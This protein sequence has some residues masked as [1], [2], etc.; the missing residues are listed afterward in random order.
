MFEPITFK[1]GHVP[2]THRMD[3]SEDREE[4]APPWKTTHR[5]PTGPRPKPRPGP[6]CVSM[7]SDDSMYEPIWLKPGRVPQTQP[8]PGPGPGPESGSG[9]GPSCVSM[10]SDASMFE[11]IEFKPSRVPQTQPGP[12][13]GPSSVSMKS[14]DSKDWLIDFKQDGSSESAIH[15]R[16]QSSG[17]DPGPSCVSFRSDRSITVPSDFS[18]ETVEQQSSE[19]PTGL[20][21]QTQLDSIFQLLEE[22]ICTFV[23]NQL[24][25]FQQVL[26]PDYPECLESLSDEDEEQRRSSE[27]FL[28]IT[29]NFLRRLKQEELEAAQRPTKKL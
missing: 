7:K 8:G 10:K 14:T 29:L 16:P 13:Q 15:Q 9:P 6:S 5:P 20:Q 1:T 28:K 12:G 2:Q 23:K 27:V 11:P 26:S 18:T 22:N 17:P 4:G 21:D 25:K 19:V 24:K 3:Q